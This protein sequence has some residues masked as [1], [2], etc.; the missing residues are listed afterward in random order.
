MITNEY[1]QIILFN[2]SDSSEMSLGLLKDEMTTRY[3]LMN[4]AKYNLNK[5]YVYFA[6]HIQL[7]KL[8]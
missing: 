7:H 2:E 5:D 8:Q 3:L 4:L 1:W 6:R